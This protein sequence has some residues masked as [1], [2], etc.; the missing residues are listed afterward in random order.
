MVPVGESLPAAWQH[1]GWGGALMS[2][3]ER[4]ASE[5]HGAR[6]LLVMSA[7]GTKRYYERLGYSRDGVYVSKRL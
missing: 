4:I 3:A 2:E 1:R 5:D 7:L 6:K